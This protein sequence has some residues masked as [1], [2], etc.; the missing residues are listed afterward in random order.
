MELKTKYQY[1][2]FIYPYIISEKRY[3][4]YILKLLKDKKCS[5]RFFE[6]EKDLD[7]YSYFLPTIRKYMFHTF[8]FTKQKIKKFR[9]MS[10]DTQAAILCKFPCVMFEYNIGNDAQGK[11]GK[12]NGIFFKVD[13]IEIICFNTGICFLNIKTNIQDS[14]SFEDVLN[15]NYKFRDINSD[16]LSLKQFDNIKIQTNT[17]EDIHKLTDL[18][19]EIAGTNSYANELDIDTD[20]FLTYSYTC[21]DQ[22]AWNDTKKFEEI[23][24]EFYKYCNIVPSNDNTSFNQEDEK[25][26]MKIISKWKYIRTGFSKI[27]SC[28]LTTGMDTFNYTKL[29]FDYENEYLYTYILT[30]YKRIYLKKLNLE[31]KKSN[32]L[33]KVRKKFIKFTQNLWIQEITNDDTG[34]LMH[35]KWNEILEI[36]DIYLEVKNK[37]DILYKEMNIE[38]NTKINKTIMV[39]LIISLLINILNFFVLFKLK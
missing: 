34:A 21:I 39:V 35:Q 25:Q 4:K 9:E 14:N 26:N 7:I 6:K 3:N 22:E 5:L 18:I 1:T 24:H 16:F 8:E 17:F 37:Y 19:Q 27:G 38:K 13:K 2:Y 30:L 36:D 15:F 28:L 20:R 32:K 33:E 29:P 31:Y 23:E 10:K 12:E 11:A